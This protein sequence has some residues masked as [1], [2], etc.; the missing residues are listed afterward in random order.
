MAA[1]NVV[2]NMKT[3]G[4]EA[5]DIML[6]GR[7]VG[8]MTLLFRERD[9]VCGSIHLERGSMSKQDKKAVMAHMRE[10]VQSFLDAVRASSCQVLVTYGDYDHFIA[11]D[12]AYEELM[13]EDGDDEDKDYEWDEE[14]SRFDDVGEDEPEWT[15]MNRLA[16]NRRKPVYALVVAREERSRIDYRIHDEAREWAAEASLRIDDAEVSG[17]VNWLFE[18]DEDEIEAATEILVADFDEGAIDSFVINHRFDGE[19]LETTELTHRDLLDPAYED[20]AEGVADAD[21]SV[22]LARDDGDTLTYDIYDQA[23]GGLP[24]ASA[25]VDIGMTQPSGFIE[26]HQPNDEAEMETIAGLLRDELGREQ[27]FDRISLTL[28]VHNKPIDEIVFDHEPY[29]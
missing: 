27:P 6:N 16:I 18:P 29:H 13:V 19:L 23:K 9:R 5:S 3:L 22:V 4:G 2:P 21:Y 14:D 15:E 25:T 17:E 1:I 10:H 28:L 11:T 26:F 12:E 7:Y 24:I 20:A 8:A